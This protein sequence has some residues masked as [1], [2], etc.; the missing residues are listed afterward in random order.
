MNN[1]TIK[2][3]HEQLLQ[4]VNSCGLPVGTAYFILKDV[5]RE[6]EKVYNECLY[7]EAHEENNSTE[8]QTINLVQ[9]EQNKEEMENEGTNTDASEYSG[10]INDN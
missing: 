1:L 8:T 6:V 10:S 5:L 2:Y 9:P 3:F 4:L 7:K